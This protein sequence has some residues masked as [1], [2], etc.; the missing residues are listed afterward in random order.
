MAE[1]E[2]T[3]LGTGTSHG[4]PVIGCDCNVCRSTDPRDN[5]TRSSVYIRTPECA[6]V[7]DTT[8]DFRSQCLRENIRHLDAVL[9]THSHTDHILGFDD[10]RRFCEMDQK[11]MPIYAA[12][13]TMADLRR[14]F[15]YAFDT[16]VFRSYVNPDPR[17]ID[18]RFH[19][20]ETEV[21]PLRLPHGRMMLNGFLFRRAGRNL[22]AYMTDCHAV[23]EEAAEVARDCDILVVDALRYTAHSTHMTVEQALEA[24]ARVRA[25]Q[26]YFIHMCHDL[27]H[28]ETDAALPEGVALSYDGLR[29]AL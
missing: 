14:V 26:T 5:R 6:F 27:P 28:A 19:L 29:V 18:G 13:D 21:I 15:A 25:R 4:V 16:Q 11:R 2:I 23:P 12:A 22:L 10:L 9:Y 8:P 1:F 3:F 20:G 24:A 7:I 17:L